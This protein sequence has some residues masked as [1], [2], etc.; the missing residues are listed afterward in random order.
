MGRVTG[1]VKGRASLPSCPN[2][3]SFLEVREGSILPHPHTSHIT[4]PGWSQALELLMTVGKPPV[5]LA[6]HC[7]PA[8]APGPSRLLQTLAALIQLIQMVAS[9]GQQRGSWNLR[10]CGA[11]APSSSVFPSESGSWTKCNDFTLFLGLVPSGNSNP[12]RKSDKQKTQTTTCGLKS[13]SL[14]SALGPC[15]PGTESSLPRLP[16]ADLPHSRLSG[17]EGLFFA[18]FRGGFEPHQAGLKNPNQRIG[19]LPTS[20]VVLDT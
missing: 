16:A 7:A 14:H 15:L 4:V 18:N 2:A 1:Q 19:G 8:G 9:P 12:T 6:P 10:H 20:P 5:P 13:Q 11:P 17:T 3:Q